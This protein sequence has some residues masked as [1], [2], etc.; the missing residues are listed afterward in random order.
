EIEYIK[1]K[2]LLTRVANALDLNFTY[3]AI[4]KIKELNIYKA[5]P[6]TVEVFK[7]RDSSGFVLNID[8]DTENSFRVNGNGPLL[9]FGQ[10]FETPNGVFRLNRN[11]LVTIGDQYKLIWQPTSVVA[12][13]FASQLVVAPRQGTGILTLTLE[14]TNPQLAAD[15]VNSVMKEYQKA[16]IEDK[17][18]KTQAELNFIDRE[19]D[20]VS[21]QLDSINNVYVDFIRRNS[22]FNLETQSS[23]YL[24]QIEEST[25]ERTTQ[26]DLINKTYQI[27]S[28]LLIKTGTIKVPSS[29]GL[30][31]PTLNKMVDAYNDAQLQ[32]KALL[33]TTLPEN[34]AV[35]H[36][37]EII[38]QLQ[39]N[40]LSSLSNIKTALR[41]S[42]AGIDRLSGTAQSQLRVMPEKQKVLAGIQR[43]QQNK[44]AVLNTLLEQRERSAIELA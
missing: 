42:L 13:G 23:T 15:V 8:F 41:S 30:D 44:I 14:S 32:R 34:I 1:S 36:Q 25:K 4:G 31:D 40:I 16:T 18:E 21:Q 3:I 12:G 35:K 17:N 5:N 10:V 43:Q 6:F 7:L 20:T 37:E 2:K 19:L 33:E 24:G 9:T 26:Q 11:S 27:E 29:L 22:A 28:N 39:K 38:D